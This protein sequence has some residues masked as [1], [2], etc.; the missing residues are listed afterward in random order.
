M[1]NIDFNRSKNHHELKTLTAEGY[2]LPG[3]TEQAGTLNLDTPAY[4]VATFFSGRSPLCIEPNTDLDTA[5]MIMKRMHVRLALVSSDDHNLLG[6]IDSRTLE[7]RKVLSE[8]F[9]KGLSRQDLSVRDIMT[10]T[11]KL[12]ALRKADV[13]KSTIGDVLTT[14]Q[15]QGNQ[16]ILVVDTTTQQILG[17]ISAGDIAR[18]LQV[19]V[20]IRH[21]AS[22]FQDVF[23]SL[24]CHKD[25]A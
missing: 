2:T 18:V 14:L 22:S 15:H 5:A 9:E 23:N 3:Y 13:L 19:P 11:T 20:D 17:I 12:A 16:H 25:I 10:P 8:A 21:R 1:D 6:V 4:L 24:Y 7:S